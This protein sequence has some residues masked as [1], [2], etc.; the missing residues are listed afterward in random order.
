MSC[1]QVS[2]WNLNSESPAVPPSSSPL[3]LSPLRPHIWFCVAVRHT[4]SRAEVL[5]CFPSILWTPEKNLETQKIVYLANCSTSNLGIL[6]F[7]IRNR[8]HP[9]TAKWLSS[10][11]PR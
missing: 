2:K 1:S 3:K 8:K 9:L 6:L 5:H 10:L 7:Y 11:E 4:R